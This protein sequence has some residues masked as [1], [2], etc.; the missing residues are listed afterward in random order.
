MN[1]QTKP[2]IAICIVCY[3]QEQYISECI[4]SVLMQK[5][6]F[7]YKIYIGDDCSTDDT[8]RICISYKNKYPDK[9]ELIRNEKNL[10]LVGNTINV[11]EK[12]AQDG[13]KYIAMLDGDDYWINDLKL[14]IQCGF[15]EKNSDFGLVYG[16]S[17]ELKNSKLLKNRK[18]R[19]NFEGSIPLETVWDEPISNNTVVFRTE[20]LKLVDMNDFIARKFMSCD[21]AMYVVFSQ[22]TKVK[23]FDE[24]F[25]V[26]RRGHSSVSHPRQMEQAIAYVENDITQFSY[27]DDYFKEKFP[28]KK[29]DLQT[30]RDYRV[31]KIAVKF[32]NYKLAHQIIKNNEAVKNR[33][34]NF[35]YKLKVFCASNPFLFFLWRFF[36]KIINMSQ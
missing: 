3:N 5:T 19:N 12:I 1:S 35:L 23:S 29:T 36:S 21:Y 6:E 24:V 11:L 34:S 15:L 31:F 10:G 20:L 28:I 27:L 14:Q 26:V 33:Q 7:P 9:I 2:L 13:I 30:H 16:I 8:N 25:A 22:F 4:E 32:G 17:W 18:L